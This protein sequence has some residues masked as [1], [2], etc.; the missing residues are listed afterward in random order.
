MTRLRSGLLRLYPPAWRE[1][2]GEEFAALLEDVPLGPHEVVDVALAALDARL[3]S[4]PGP[5]VV[6]GPPVLSLR[7]GGI[8]A[9]WGGVLWSMGWLLMALG[10]AWQPLGVT[11]NFF[12]TFAI[13]VAI[14]G[15]SAFQ[16]AR[17]PAVAWA[18][19]ALPA[20]GTIMSLTAAVIAATGQ[21]VTLLPDFG[22]WALW[23]L[24]IVALLGGSLLF[25]IASWRIAAL[26]RLASLLIAGA[27]AMG[28]L[29][30]VFAG[31][32]FTEVP[33]LLA[34][35]LTLSAAVLFGCGWTCLGLD[36]IRRDRLAEAALTGLP[37]A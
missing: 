23:M 9:V 26:S 36:A 15:L 18:A 31:S 11:G 37:S 8:A 12:G 33:E 30:L 22:T 28:I 17:S 16:A 29:I 4:A 14:V 21:E 34:I 24:G 32:G 25:G 2:Y 13:L 3:H 27:G 10:G 6:S 1:R 5:A 7:V 35:V 19:A 20:I